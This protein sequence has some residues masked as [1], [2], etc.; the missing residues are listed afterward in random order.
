MIINI[1][2]SN[3][4]LTKHF[5]QNKMLME[6]LMS[7]LCFELNQGEYFSELCTCLRA[8]Q[9]MT[10]C[11]REG[12]ESY[13]KIETNTDLCMIVSYR[14]CNCRTRLPTLEKKVLDQDKKTCFASGRVTWWSEII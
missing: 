7:T 2:L 10:L 13:I 6:L 14:S 4:P 11:P 5:D 8:L 12:P 9:N 1:T 3:N